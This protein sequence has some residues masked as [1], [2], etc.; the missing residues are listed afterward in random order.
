TTETVT[1]AITSFTAAYTARPA[2][3]SISVIGVVMMLRRLR[4]H[5]SSMKPVVTAIWH[6]NKT[7]N[8]MMPASRYG[9]AARD[10]VFSCATNAPSDPNNSTS[11][12]GHT[13]MSNHRFGLRHNTYQWR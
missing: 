6:W 5:V 3:Y 12:T 7:W 9:A 13:A 2:V 8:S 10:E 4:L 11:N 1:I